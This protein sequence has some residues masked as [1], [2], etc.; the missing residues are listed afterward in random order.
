MRRVR[1]ASPYMVVALLSLTAV[2]ATSAAVTIAANRAAYDV[3]HRLLW[4]VLSRRAT[5]TL[6][7]ITLFVS[8][9]TLPALCA[10]WAR[11]VLLGVFLRR[12]LRGHIDRARCPRCRYV[13][14]GQRVNGSCVSCPECGTATPLGD[15]GIT[16]ED[17]I[18]RE[19]CGPGYDG[20]A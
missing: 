8:V 14:L 11:D 18:P 9:G 16:R 12:A 6:L 4:Q 1:V 17:L 5:E 2:I 3:L 7:L 19:P 13:L 15:L 10:F 20:P